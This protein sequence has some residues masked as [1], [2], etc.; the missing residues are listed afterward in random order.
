M[1]GRGVDAVERALRI[2][3]VFVDGREAMTLHQLAEH[4]GLYKSTVLRMCVSLERFGYIVR[5][6]DGIFRLGPSLWRLGSLYSRAFKLSD[7]VYPALNRLVEQT[8]ECATLYVRQ[9]SHRI[10]LHRRQSPLRLRHHVDEGER[11]PLGRG[12][13][14]S[15]VLMAFSGEKGQVNERVREQ[16]Y[17][18]SMGEVDP[19]IAAVAAPVFGWD[20]ALVGAL[21]V[22]GAKSRFTPA[23]VREYRSILV[24]EAGQLTRL[25][26]GEGTARKSGRR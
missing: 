11:R 19:D 1:T 7:Y 8:K 6:E 22:S 24:A 16:G 3:D 23:K 10:C 26:S 13:A 5:G 14:G 12:G 15:R 20:G 9:G 17:C 2:L 21:A 4:T 18:V 25:L